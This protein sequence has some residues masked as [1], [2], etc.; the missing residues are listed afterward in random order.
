[1]T[2]AELTY[3]D[4]M[5]VGIVGATGLVGEFMIASL[6]ERKFPVR[7]MRLFASERSAGKRLPWNCWAR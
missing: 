6:L 2:D 7:S 1:M 3:P 5:N 4:G